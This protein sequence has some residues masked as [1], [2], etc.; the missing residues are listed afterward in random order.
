MATLAAG[1]SSPHAGVVADARPGSVTGRTLW[2]QLPTGRLTLTVGEPVT[3]IPG[4]EVVG[5]K[6]VRADDGRSFVPVEITY[7]DRVGVPWNAPVAS[8]KSADPAALTKV[9]LV[10]GGEAHALELPRVT[11]RSYVETTSAD[12][13]RSPALKVDFDGVAQSVDAAG[14]RVTGEAAGLYTAST[15]RSLVSCGRHDATRPPGAPRALG[16]RCDYDLWESPWLAGRGW[17]FEKRPG[18][19]WV[20]ATGDV[21]LRPDELRRG[22]RTCSPDELTGTLRL[23]VDGA[24]LTDDL[25]HQQLQPPGFGRLVAQDA[26]LLPPATDHELELTSTW[27]C[28]IAGRTVEQTFVDRAAQ[29][30]R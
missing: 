29:P 18:T 6:D 9:A 8:R 5:G 15:R 3:T 27:R 14:K 1:C 20:V 2:A 24:S 21:L 11:T 30:L 25:V 10:L 7:H 19:T 23:Q 28:R 4:D 17:A 13:K 26:F 22:A 16:R 12:A